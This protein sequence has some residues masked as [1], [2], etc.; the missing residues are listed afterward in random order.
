MKIIQIVPLS[1][2]QTMTLSAVEAIRTADKLYFQTIETP[3]VQASL[4]NGLIYE[5][6][7]DLY[8]SCEDFDALSAAIAD[9]LC[10]GA[11]CVYAV[12]GD[13][14]FAH[15]PAIKKAAGERGFTVHALPGISYAKAAFPEIQEGYFCT[16]GALPIEPITEKPL[17]VQELHSY[18][19]AGDVKLFLLEH[20]PAYHP[21][22]LASLD[23][24]GSYHLQSMP[25]C[26]LDRQRGKYHATSVLCVPPLDLLEKER[27]SFGD[28]LRIMQQLRAPGGCPW[29]KEQTH[30]SLKRPLLEECYELLDAID[31]GDDAMLVEELG[32]VLLQVVFHAVIGEEQGSFQARD[33]STAITQKLIYRHPHIFGTKIVHTADEVL[34]SW[35]ELK[36]AEK[37]QETVSETLFAVPRNFP[38]LLRAQKVQKRAEKVGFDWDNAQAA[39]EKLPEEFS[40]LAIA[41]REKSNISEELG[42]LLFTIVNIARLLHFDAEEI[43]HMGTQKFICR[44]AI[45]EKLAAE[46]NEDLQNMSF[47]RQ[48]ELW[49]QSKAFEMK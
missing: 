32:D 31:A 3:C 19:L 4:C 25:L 33:I 34:R 15:L 36:Q 24:A 49:E 2:P 42:D 22:Q 46:N 12:P 26:E 21:V 45:M 47:S 17:L 20:Y 27:N 10:S 7:D 40:E 38:A 13:G 11:S 37:G 8:A 5:S 48:N 29:D 43:M 41:L 35:D 28:L 18:T 23:A 44:F 6:M 14:C 39:F 1:T 9:R 30:E 16:A